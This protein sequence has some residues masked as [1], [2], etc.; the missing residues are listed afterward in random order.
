MLN[1]MWW[2]WRWGIGLA[3]SKP[4]GCIDLCYG[5]VS[6]LWKAGPF[7]RAETERGTIIIGKYGPLWLAR[8]RNRDRFGRIAL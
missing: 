2:I 1:R 5:T 8:R 7:L 3:P 4:Y 6:G